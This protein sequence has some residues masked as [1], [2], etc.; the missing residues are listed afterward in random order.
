MLY[1]TLLI[2]L[3]FTFLNVSEPIDTWGKIYLKNYFDEV[4]VNWSTM[5]E[6]N[7]K[8]FYVEESYNTRT[9]MVIDSLPAIGG[10]SETYY[11]ITY[12][13]ELQGDIYIRIRKSNTDSTF[14]YSPINTV[15]TLQTIK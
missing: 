6:C 3:L 13:T 11:G 14:A 15:N 5:Q 8:M 4:S 12:C 2:A 7:E 9:W 1:K 10:N